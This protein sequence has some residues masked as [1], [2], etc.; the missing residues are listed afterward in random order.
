MY[1]RRIKDT[2]P[3]LFTRMYRSQRRERQMGTNR[4]GHGNLR[5]I[6]QRNKIN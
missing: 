6:L 4:L 3:I 1:P 2:F 5:E